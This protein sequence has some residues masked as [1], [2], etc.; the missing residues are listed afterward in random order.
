MQRLCKRADRLHGLM[1]GRMFASTCRPCRH[2][3]N[4]LST[5]AHACVCIKH[6]EQKLHHKQS[7]LD[8]LAVIRTS[9]SIQKGPNNGQQNGQRTWNRLPTNGPPITRTVAGFL[10]A[11]AKDPVA[12]LD[13]DSVGCR[14][15]VRS[16]PHDCTL[17]ANDDTRNFTYR[18]LHCDIY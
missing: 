2:R 3:S 15:R 4:V 8:T 12:A 7:L 18:L 14:C 16:R 6:S 5:A 10:Q 13:T 9:N 17:T 11:P 1:Y